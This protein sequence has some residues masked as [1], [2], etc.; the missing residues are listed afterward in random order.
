[1][2]RWQLK[3]RKLRKACR[4]DCTHTTKFDRDKK[5]SFAIGQSIKCFF[6][7]SDAMRLADNKACII[8]LQWN[9]TFL[10]HSKYYQHINNS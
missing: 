6:L 4:D 10:K 2:F 7:G 1:M 8:I 5:C 3:I 9:R